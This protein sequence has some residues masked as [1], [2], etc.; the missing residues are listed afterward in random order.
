MRVLVC[1]GRYYENTDA[2]HQELIR[3][4]WRRRLRCRSCCGSMG[5]AQSR[6]RRALSAELGMPGQ[7]GGAAQKRLHAGGQPSRFR[8]RVSGRTGYGRS[9]PRKRWRPASEFC[10][11]PRGRPATKRW[12]RARQAGR[13]SIWNTRPRIRSSSHKCAL[14]RLDRMVIGERHKQK[15]DL[16]ANR[17]GYVVKKCDQ[18]V[19]DALVGHDLFAFVIGRWAHQALKHAMTSLLYML[20]YIEPSN[21]Y[22]QSGDGLPAT[23]PVSN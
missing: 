21:R 22:W 9:G 3:L 15:R 20:G 14:F 1:G 12:S 16:G 23:G 17:I 5:A 7:A 13:G 4:H 19:E 8:G 18:V 10:T 2:V 6:R 11:R